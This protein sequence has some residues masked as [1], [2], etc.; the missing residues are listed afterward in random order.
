MN[1]T[2]LGCIGQ[3]I[4]ASNISF[5]LPFMKACWSVLYDLGGIFVQ[6]VAS[7]GMLSL[8]TAPGIALTS[9]MDSAKQSAYS[10]SSF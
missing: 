8:C 7:F 5:T 9:L 10:S 6:K 2:L 3:T 1:H 4:P